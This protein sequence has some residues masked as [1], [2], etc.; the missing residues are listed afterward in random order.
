M[1]GYVR[2]IVAQRNNYKIYVYILKGVY[3]ETTSELAAKMNQLHAFLKKCQRI[4]GFFHGDYR[5]RF[6]TIRPTK[7]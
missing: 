6:K 3:N 7:I 4:I 2:Q 5:V 1:Y